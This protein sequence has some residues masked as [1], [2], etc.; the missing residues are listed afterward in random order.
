MNIKSLGLVGK[1]KLV[2]IFIAFLAATTLAFAMGDKVET[3][4]WRYK[5]TVTVDTPEGE[6]SG[7]AVREMCNGPMS[8]LSQNGNPAKV[9]G[10]AVV[11][12]MC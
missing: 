5:M 3:Y 10:E 8:P 6:V 12:D 2:V 11:V 4:S 1:Y 9:R 7:S